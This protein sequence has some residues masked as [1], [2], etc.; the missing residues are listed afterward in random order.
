[1]T[2]SDVKQTFII[3]MLLFWSLWFF[4]AGLSNIC[5]LLIFHHILPNTISFHSGNLGLLI[6]VVSVYGFGS[7]FAS[8]LLAVDAVT[9]LLIADCFFLAL[10]HYAGS[11]AKF[12]LWVNVAFASVVLFWMCFILLSEVFVYYKFNTLFFVLMMAGIA[13]WNWVG[14]VMKK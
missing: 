3:I 14:V 10:F 5:D 1:M 8:S 7:S 6:K 2:D 4:I 11:K 13:S 12:K 9:Q